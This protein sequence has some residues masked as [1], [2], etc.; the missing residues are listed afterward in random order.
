MF[1]FSG[2]VI[3]NS[4]KTQT[5]MRQGLGRYEWPFEADIS[6][7]VL[8]WIWCYSDVGHSNIILEKSIMNFKVGRLL[9]AM[10]KPDPVI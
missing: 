9:A 5:L 8:I 2:L 7:T 10:N 6:E 1:C 3:I 4:N